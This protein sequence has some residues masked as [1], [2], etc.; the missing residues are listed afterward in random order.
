MY[1]E[2]T[3]PVFLAPRIDGGND[4]T[5][6][7]GLEHEAN[8]VSHIAVTMIEN[9]SDEWFEFRGTRKVGGWVVDGVG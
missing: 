1:P 6:D 8:P 5:V 7:M 2:G 4:G 3:L 9:R